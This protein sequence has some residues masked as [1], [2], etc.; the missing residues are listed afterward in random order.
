MDRGTV[1]KVPGKAE[2]SAKTLSRCAEG[3]LDRGDLTGNGVNTE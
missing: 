1:L 2:D 3:R